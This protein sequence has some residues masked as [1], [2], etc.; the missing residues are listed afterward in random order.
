MSDLSKRLRE[1]ADLIATRG[2]AEMWPEKHAD[3]LAAASAIEAGEWREIATHDGTER[4]V[5]LVDDEG[6][7]YIGQ[8]AKVTDYSGTYMDWCVIGQNGSNTGRIKFTHWRPLPA[9]PEVTR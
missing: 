6:I 3:L 7:V 8:Y 4:A 5:E 9:P 1:W 2:A